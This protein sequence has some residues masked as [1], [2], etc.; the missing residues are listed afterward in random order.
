MPQFW[1]EV[2]K[3]VQFAILLAVGIKIA[4][5]VNVKPYSLVDKYQLFG[6][7]CCFIFIEEEVAVR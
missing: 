3:V 7:N 1:L 5:F 4:V 6:E 2:Q